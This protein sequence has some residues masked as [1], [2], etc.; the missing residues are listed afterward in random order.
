VKLENAQAA[1]DKVDRLKI[2]KATLGRIDGE[3]FPYSGFAP[4]MAQ[5]YKDAVKI[6]IALEIEKLE[7]EIAEL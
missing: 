7:R 3:V 5:S 6:G 2:H 1:F 4:E